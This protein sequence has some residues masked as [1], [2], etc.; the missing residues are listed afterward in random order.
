MLKEL[1]AA[2]KSKSAL[3]A[4]ASAPE[5]P[6]VTVPSNLL[7]VSQ[8]S[9]HPPLVQPAC[10]RCELTRGV[11]CVR[12]LQERMQTLGPKLETFTAG[13]TKKYGFDGGFHEAM[14]SIA[15][16]GGEEKDEKIRCATHTQPLFLP[17]STAVTQPLY[18]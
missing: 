13:V 14:Q 9:Q 15:A 3:E 1:K 8:P 12:V 17:L 5:E 2:F 4:F 10:D 7:Q 16:V 18:S 6:Q 11:I